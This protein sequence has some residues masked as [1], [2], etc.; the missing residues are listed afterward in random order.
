VA[1]PASTPG[2]NCSLVFTFRPLHRFPFLVLL[3]VLTENY[4]AAAYLLAGS[5]E[6]LSDC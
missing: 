2:Q 1:F 6:F 3:I 5:Q 4:H